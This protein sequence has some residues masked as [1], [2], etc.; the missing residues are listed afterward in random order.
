MKIAAHHIKGTKE[1]DFSEMIRPSPDYTPTCA[2]PDNCTVQ[3][4][5]GIVPAVPFFEAFIPGTFIRGEGED[6]AAAERKAFEQYQSEFSCDHHWSRCR[7]YANG[8]E[9]LYHNGAGFCRKCGA[10]R[11]SMFRPIVILGDMRKPLSRWESDWLETLETRDDPAFEAHMERKYP[12]HAADCEKS[13]KR[14][15]LRMNLFGAAS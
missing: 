1:N 6:I 15:R 13:R 10:F 4:G 12:G 8:T 14:L 2:W 9:S 3:W 7:V 5:H 11:G